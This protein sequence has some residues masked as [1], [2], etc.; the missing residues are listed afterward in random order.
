MKFAAVYNCTPDRLRTAP[1]PRLSYL[2]A[3]KTVDSQYFVT[4]IHWLRGFSP[5]LLHILVI[6]PPNHK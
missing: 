1:P 5:S 6:C 2:S 3:R 4:E